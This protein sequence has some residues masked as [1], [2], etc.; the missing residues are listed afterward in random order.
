MCPPSVPDSPRPVPEPCRAARRH[1]V[2]RDAGLTTP[3]RGGCA[4]RK[5]RWRG[6][7]VTADRMTA[8]DGAA[9]IRG[10]LARLRRT[11][12]LPVAFGGLVEP[13]RQQVRISELSGTATPALSSL[14]VTAGNGLGGKALALA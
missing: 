12:G 13:G 10:A 7:Q 5:P 14:A 11:T 9:E 4:R 2:I 3:E 6:E 1:R 8:V